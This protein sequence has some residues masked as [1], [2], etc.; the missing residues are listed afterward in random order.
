MN[1]TE[2]AAWLANYMT[3]AGA[4]AATETP[5]E[6]GFLYCK[7]SE[8][9]PD[10]AVFVRKAVPGMGLLSGYWTSLVTRNSVDRLK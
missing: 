6:R 9:T 3:T 2:L 1:R 5:V 7:P 8:L 4:A 10:L